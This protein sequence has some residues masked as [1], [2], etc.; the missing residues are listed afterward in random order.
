VLSLGYP[1]YERLDQ[2]IYRETSDLLDDIERGKCRVGSLSVKALVSRISEVGNPFEGAKAFVQQAR[3]GAC[4]ASARKRGTPPVCVIHG[5]RTKIETHKMAQRIGGLSV[6]TI[7]TEAPWNFPVRFDLVDGVIVMRAT[8]ATARKF[9]LPPADAEATTR[10]GDFDFVDVDLAAL[11]I[12]PPRLHLNPAS[13]LQDA[14]LYADVF[15][16][17]ER[18]CARAFGSVDFVTADL[19]PL[20]ARPRPRLSVKGGMDMEFA[21]PVPE[22]RRE[23]PRRRPGLLEKVTRR[24]SDNKSAD[25]QEAIR[26]FE[27]C[28]LFDRDWYLETYSD[29]AANRL[30]PSRHYLEFGW[31]EGRDPSPAFSSKLYLKDNPDVAQQEV[32]PLL[33]Y[34]RFGQFEGRKV[35]PRIRP[36]SAGG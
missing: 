10:I 15:A 22:R 30:D 29:V 25:V 36:G 18:C 27:E 33:H 23:P 19:S 4:R 20:V 28:A 35:R 11:Q 21:A 3:D 17:A 31:R 9:A 24:I 14:I 32:N 12:E 1:L 34:I 26:L 5:R 7:F 2:F 8:T 13:L 16:F 6:G